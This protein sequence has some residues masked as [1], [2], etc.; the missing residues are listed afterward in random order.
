M[1]TLASGTAGRIA[2]TGEPRSWSSSRQNVVASRRAPS[3]SAERSLR[4]LRRWR[5]RAPGPFRGALDRGEHQ[6]I[7]ELRA[8]AYLL[9]RLTEAAREV[10]RGLLVKPEHHEHVA[11]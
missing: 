7:G 1:A 10:M 6:A 8:A 4:S 5:D 9:D 2:A 3:P 11:A